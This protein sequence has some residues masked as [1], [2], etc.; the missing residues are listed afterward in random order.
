VSK[1]HAMRTLGR[2]ARKEWY[3]SLGLKAMWKDH[4]SA[5][6]AKTSCRV[7][8][9][10]KIIGLEIDVGFEKASADVADVQAPGTKGWAAIAPGYNQAER[11]PHLADC[12]ALR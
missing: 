2:I 7:A 6:R 10:E 12:E 8:N 3:N 1:S 4:L 9:R 11:K 5:N